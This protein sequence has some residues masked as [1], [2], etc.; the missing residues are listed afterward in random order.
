MTVLKL[1]L[2]D[3]LRPG[4]LDQS[5]CLLQAFDLVASYTT[6]Q[7]SIE[8]ALLFETYLE[9]NRRTFEPETAS[10][11]NSELRITKRHQTYNN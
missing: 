10:H 4:Q 3:A 9:C 7:S 2:L 6:P 11:G 5:L 1:I 8:N